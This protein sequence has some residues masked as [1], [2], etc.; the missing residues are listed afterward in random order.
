M[1]SHERKNLQRIAQR[2]LY[3]AIK[4]GELQVSK[5]CCRCKSREYVV[6]HHHD[7]TKP[8][9]TISLCRS[10]HVTEHHRLKR[11]GID[12]PV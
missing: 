8:L 3:K 1:D 12:L 5:V 2:I 10:C 4:D 9:D 6:N 7:Y 11:L